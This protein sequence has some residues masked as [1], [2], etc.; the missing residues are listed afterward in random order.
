MENEELFILI[1]KDLAGD[2]SEKESQELQSLLKDPANQD[3]YDE[4]KH[5]WADSSKFKVETGMDATS[6]WSEFRE[7]LLQRESKQTRV[8][9]LFYRIAALVVLTVGLGYY[10]L[11]SDAPLIAY[12]TQPGENRELVL[13]DNSTIWLNESST[14]TVR[15]DFNTDTRTVELSGEAFFDIAR[16]EDKPFI[17]LGQGAQVEV[18]GTSFNVQAY[19]DIPEVQVSVATGLVALSQQENPDNRILLQPGMSGV[20]NIDGGSLASFSNV[21]ENFMAWRTKTL[22]FD[23]VPLEQVVK[24]LSDYFKVRIEIGNSELAPCRFT[25]TFDDPTL[26]EILKVLSLTLDISYKQVNNKYVLE[27]RGCNQ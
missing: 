11:Q 9:P 7:E 19:E 12:S 18:L 1:G 15:N 26:E 25:S 2:I 6:S 23:D 13:A 22:K 17:I 20:F 10:F 16:N 27:G 14:L 5:N 8:I 21:G 3:T 4:L 24:D